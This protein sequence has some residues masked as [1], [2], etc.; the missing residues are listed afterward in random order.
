MNGL[1]KFTANP[2]YQ[3]IFYILIL[4]EKIKGLALFI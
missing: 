2:T 3:N 1:L 4:N